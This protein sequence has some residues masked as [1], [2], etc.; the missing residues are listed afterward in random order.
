LDNKDIFIIFDV[1]DREGTGSAEGARTRPHA[2]ERK[3][4]NLDDDGKP[5]QASQKQEIGECFYTFSPFSGMH[6]S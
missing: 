3:K 6:V 2:R 4:P 5:Y 1:S